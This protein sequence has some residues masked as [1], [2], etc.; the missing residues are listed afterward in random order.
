MSSSV[1]S[2]RHFS[3]RQTPFVCCLILAM[4]VYSVILPKLAHSAN[5]TVGWDAV[6]GAVGYK[7][8]YGTS[9]GSYTFPVG[10]VTAP[11]TSYA[12]PENLTGT[13]YFIAASATDGTAESPKSEELQIYSMTASAGAGGAIAPS[14]S[15][16]VGSGTNQPFTITPNTGYQVASVTVDGTSVGAVTSYTFSNVAAAHSISA[17]FTAIQT[18]YTITST[19]GANGSISP[20]PSATVNSGANQTFTITPNSGYK[21]A[22]VTVDGAALSNPVSSYTFSNVT[23]NHSIAAT[24]AINTYTITSSAG[25]NGSISPAP[26]VTVGSGASQTFTI[27]PS[28]GYKVASVTVDGTAL[29]NPVSSYTFSNVTANHS[30]AAT[31]A[32]NTYTITSSAGAN[33]SISPT[34]SA[35]VN[36]GANQT[37]TITPNS[38]YKVASVTVDGAALANPVTSYTFSNVTANHS[39]AAT[40]AI[41]TYTITSSAGSNGSIS[42]TPSATVNSGTSQTFTI[43]PNSGYKVAS[44]TVDGN[45]LSNPVTSYTFSNVT[46]NHSIAATFAINTYTITSSAGANGSISPTPSATVSSG[47]NQTF[48]ITPNSG[49][50]VASVTVDGTALSNP[51]TSYT[52][53]NVTANHSIA[54]TFAI[55][56]Y[57]ITSSA[58]ANG[59]ISPTPS[60]TVNSGA[61]QTF[62]ITPNSGYK[63]ASVTVDGNALINPVTSYTFSN[64]TAKHSIAAT[65][66]PGDQPPV[67]DAGPDQTV[68]EA[69]LVTLNGSNSSDPALSPLSY[70][71]TQTDGDRVSLSSQTAARPTFTSPSVGTTGTALTFQ[72]TVTNALGLQSTDTC[73]VN[74]TW[75]NA[76]PTASAGPNQ[77]V[78]EG[79][80]VTLDASDSTDPDDGIAS[81]FWEQIAG[82]AVTL[83]STTSQQAMFI[84][85]NVIEGSTSLTFR[86]TVTDNGGLK[87]TAT[88][89]VNVTW[90]N[91]PPQAITGSDQSVYEGDVVV[92]DGSGSSDPDDGIK[93]YMWKQTSGSAVTLTDPTSV[94]PSFTAPNVQATVTTVK[95]TSTKL[96]KSYATFSFPFI[97]PA[98]LPTDTSSDTSPA[99]DS[100]TDTTLTFLLTVTDSGGLQSTS[101]CNVYVKT[102]QGSDLT[103]SWSKLTYSRSTL[104]GS[105]ILKNVGNQ[106]AGSFVTKFHIS[107]D[108]TTLG[109]LIKQTSLSYLNPAQSK[110]V[111]FKYSVKGV[112]GKYV[113]A[114]VDAANRIAES[115]E[116][117][118]QIPVVI[119]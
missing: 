81:Y 100:S 103:G 77:T 117:N 98:T 111:S 3:L 61:N 26:S 13:R 64:V 74:V 7:V 87:S 104:Y 22:S 53:S 116:E 21:V 78:P 12:I 5:V 48:T 119:P 63:V 106:K 88:C 29:S 93:S 50:K 80:T 34:P 70:L 95:K 73:I 85:P 105:F 69:S 58:G 96:K 75:V 36:S 52:F 118:N 79:A 66:S 32:I 86:V 89:V 18:N 99:S 43:T 2:K 94:Q 1:K 97:F 54:A 41:N 20:T 59:S 24:F 33:G 9:S 17:T 42:P 83:T 31:F 112:S 68:Q 39:I 55:N 90:V 19:A 8:Y 109:K 102:K 108:G 57:T 35:T 60:A 28:S 65:F 84:A 91:S 11:A 101:T 113:I 27:T 14:G 67:A 23:A 46:A 6:S 49:Y 4:A 38:G 82:P 76:S 45:A 115:S 110:T 15:F 44:V 16:Y 37:F 92:L 10:N 62:T 72:L 40:F 25:S 47:A 107:D 114:V 71:W 30:I 51:V 56:T